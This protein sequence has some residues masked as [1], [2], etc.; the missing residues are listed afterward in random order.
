MHSASAAKAVGQG[1][2]ADRCSETQPSSTQARCSHRAQREAR[3]SSRQGADTFDE[4]GLRRIGTGLV[5][6]EPTPQLIVFARQQQ[7]E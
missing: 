1:G 7:L 5:A 3:H 4:V 2:S 6:H